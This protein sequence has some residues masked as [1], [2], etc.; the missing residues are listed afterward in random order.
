MPLEISPKEV[1]AKKNAGEKL[2]LI[3]VR[4]QFEWDICHIEG[5]NL[6]PMNTVPQALQQ[7][8]AQSDETTLVVYCHH[9][10]RSLNVVNWLR[11][12]GVENCVSMS[13]GIDRW[14]VEVDLTVPRY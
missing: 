1:V 9:G 12:Q 13:G 4:E 10:V 2:C 8:E 14:S 6:V 5:A 7:L 3:D 11:G